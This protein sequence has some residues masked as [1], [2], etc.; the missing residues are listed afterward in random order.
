MVV[1]AFRS[2]DQRGVIDGIQNRRETLRLERMVRVFF[3]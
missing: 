1:V 2:G 3:A